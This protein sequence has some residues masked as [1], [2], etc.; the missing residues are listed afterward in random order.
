[1]A[2]IEATVDATNAKVTLDITFAPTVNT[3]TVGRRDPNGFTTLIRYGEAI[4]L[5]DAGHV[6]IEDHE[7]P[8]DVALHY[9]AVQVDPP[10]SEQGQSQDVIVP[11]YGYSWL[12]DPGYPSMNIRIDVV[13][14]I[15]QLDRPHRAGVFNILDRTNPIVVSARRSGPLG[16]LVCHTLT[17]GTRTSL[18][19]LLARGSILQLSTPA[20]YGFGSEY[21]HVG[22]TEEVRVGLAMRP[23]RRWVMPFIVVDRPDGLSVQPT[24]EKTWQAVKETYASWAE[25]TASGK[26]YQQLLEE[27][28]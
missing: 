2:T 6:L 27:G 17:D 22:D 12:K 5:D 7:A 19:D 13:T 24:E 10:G 15:A 3:I 25:L 20:A 9:L 23:E 14:S 21:I 18:R 1:M 26:T 11:S 16:E 8:F 4:P 28:P